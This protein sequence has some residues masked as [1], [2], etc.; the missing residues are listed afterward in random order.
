VFSIQKFYLRDWE[1]TDEF[2]AKFDVDSIYFGAHTLKRLVDMCGKNCQF[3]FNSLL[4][5]SNSAMGSRFSIDCR[6]LK[7]HPLL[8]RGLNA[9]AIG[10]ERLPNIRLCDCHLNA[11][12]GHVMSIYITLTGVDR[13][14]QSNH[15]CHEELAII[16]A[17][18]N[19]ATCGLKQKRVHQLYNDSVMRMPKFET[20]VRG[21]FGN[22]VKNS[23]VSF[24]PNVMEGFAKLFDDSLKKIL[25][26]TDLIKFLDPT[27]TGMRFDNKQGLDRVKLN[28]ARE[29]L[30]RGVHFTASLAGIKDIFKED[31]T[32]IAGFNTTLLNEYNSTE[33]SRFIETGTHNAYNFL[34]KKVFVKSVVNEKDI[35]HFD[36]GLEIVPSFESDLSFLVNMKYAKEQLK[37]LFRK[38]RTDAA[39]TSD[40]E[41]GDED[42]Y[43]EDGNV[44]T[45]PTIRGRESIETSMFNE[46]EQQLMDIGEVFSQFEIDDQEEINV[47]SQTGSEIAESEVH[48]NEFEPDED[49]EISIRDLFFESRRLGVNTYEKL[50]SNGNIGG[51]HSGSALLRFKEHNEDDMTFADQERVQ[52][53]REILS[54]RT[55]MQICGGQVYDPGA[56]ADFLTKQRKNVDDFAALPNLVARLLSSNRGSLDNNRKELYSDFLDLMT[57]LAYFIEDCCGSMKNSSQHSARFEFFFASTLKSPLPDIVFP[58]IDLEKFLIVVD[59]DELVDA[60]TDDL[61]ENLAPLTSLADEIAELLVRDRQTMPSPEKLCP[62]VKTRLVCCS[63]IIVSLIEARGF[64]GRVIKAIQSELLA[65]GELSEFFDIPATYKIPL[66]ASDQT[67]DKIEFGLPPR[68]LKLPKVSPVQ[69]IAIR[70]YVPELQICLFTCKS[71][72]ATRITLFVEVTR[73][74]LQY[75]FG[76]VNRD[77]IP[78]LH[79]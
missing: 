64:Q 75:C 27:W 72:N 52:S 17:A 59:H 39:Y 55:G 30:K 70:E 71:G 45:N 43:D 28:A 57:N 20:K 54:S 6:D 41:D 58:D 13:I 18:L 10:Y 22:H 2:I 16:N 46:T 76:Y 25:E 5:H 21:K 51:V 37:L 65:D 79:I 68:L 34:R 33:F 8:L 56:M 48:T 77:R 61:E 31:E 50:L 19:L 35:Y 9:G 38:E 69:I 36:L 44:N 26:R 74:E 62:S 15:L 7:Y 12:P 67:I 1:E 66:S 47:V 73:A 4:Y 42:F 14:R 78:E 11:V 40:V 63:E 24:G 60:I 32:F 3:S 49:N 23:R 53:L 29:C